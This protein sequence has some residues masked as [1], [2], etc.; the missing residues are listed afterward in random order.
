VKS[1]WLIII[2]VII[3]FA[4][5]QKVRAQEVV[6]ERLLDAI[7]QI[8][9]SGRAD[10]IGDGGK[11]RGMFQLH[12]AAW[13]DAQKRNPLVVDYE[14]GSMNPAQSRLAA[15]TYLTI[16]AARFERATSRPPQP[17]ELYAAYNVGFARFAS[18]GFD[19]TKTPKTTQRAIA[20][21]KGVK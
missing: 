21:L 11:A 12:R 1:F 16:L 13:R 3:A 20:K 17:G 8:E 15:R 6:S 5:C 14:T 10:A 9:S 19:V 2:V 4:S 7:A 18:L